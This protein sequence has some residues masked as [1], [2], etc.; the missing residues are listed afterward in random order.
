MNLEKTWKT[1]LGELEVTLS[2]AN[3]TTWFKDTF[4]GSL[5]DKSITI[6]VP[7]AFTREW[8]QNKYHQ[9]IFTALKKIIPDLEEVEYK[10]MSKSATSQPKVDLEK[11]TAKATQEPRE[12]DFSLRPE[13]VFENF[14]VGNSNRLAH[15]AAKAVTRQPGKKYNPL[16]VYG[17]VGLGKTHLIQAI[18]HAL[19][20]GG[21]KVVYVSCERFT[22]EFIA[23]IRSNRTE[24][25]KRKYRDID[26]LLI[27]DIQFL[28]GKEGTQEEFFHTFNALHEKHK[29]IIISSDRPPK[30]IPT[31]ED[32]LKSRFEWGM[33]VDI[34]QPDFEMRKA[35]LQAKAAEREYKLPDDVIS[36]I[37]E[38]I[39]QNIRELEGALNRLVA[40][41]ELNNEEP[42]I[43]IASQV[44]GKVIS[45]KSTSI[46]YEKI[47]NSISKHYNVSIDDLMSS[48]RVKEVVT[49]RQVAMYLL[50]NELNYSYPQ[51]AT[52]IGKKDHTTVMYACE[53]I[54]KNLRNDENLQKDMN[55]I[56]E[57]LY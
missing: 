22:N 37:A 36:Y 34:S 18:G 11:I 19:K 28:A 24:A 40:F 27:D 35:I 16:F 30:A 32:R 17:G 20:E 9:E 49:P 50:R 4:I 38:K 6:G 3:F 51:I 23:S 54:E 12:I 15:A 41:V 53:K 33:I 39:Q 8:L 47:L 1:A 7:N 14:I 13:Y 26:A 44:L 31:L 45:P 10:V 42:T 29:Q 43:E 25:F 52:R 55:L 5:K 57:T 48:K 56:K 46:S 2:R 21:K